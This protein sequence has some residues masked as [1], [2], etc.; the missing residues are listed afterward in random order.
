MCKCKVFEQA[1]L[2][3]YRPGKHKSGVTDFTC[4]MC[5]SEKKKYAMHGNDGDYSGYVFECSA[6]HSYLRYF[7][8]CADKPFKDEFYYDDYCIVQEEKTIFVIDNNGVTALTIPRFE[9]TNKEHFLN[10]IKIYLTFK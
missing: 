4:L 10:K 3:H 6:C 9:F 8:S 2:Y 5:S 1:K 7:E